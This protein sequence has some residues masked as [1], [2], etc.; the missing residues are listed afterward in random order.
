[1]QRK[2]LTGFSFFF[3]TL[4]ATGSIQPLA[5]H[6]ATYETEQS[7]G[8]Y[9]SYQT[10]D[11]NEDGT[12]DAVALT[13]CD[14]SVTTITVPD[15]I[16]GLP[17]TSIGRSAFAWCSDLVS[18]TLPDTLTT[19]STN[20][21][22]QCESLVSLAIP[23]QVSEIA[24]AA[25]VG[26]DS[27]RF[28][29]VDADNQCYSSQ[30]GVLFDKEQTTLL[31]Y[32]ASHST[33]RYSIP[34]TVTMIYDYAFYECRNL[35]SVTMPDSVTR[36]CSWAFAYC[37]A[38]TDITI[39]DSVTSIST[40]AFYHCSGLKSVSIGSGIKTIARYTFYS[41]SGLQ[42]VS[43]PKTV[44]SIQASAFESCSLLATIN[45]WNPD[46]TI[47]DS[48]ATICNSATSDG[49]FVFYGAV[50]GFADSGA[51]TYANTYGYRFLEFEAYALGDVNNDKLID[52]ADATAVLTAYTLSLLGQSVDWNL[53][54]QTAADI[55]KD[56]L[57]TADDATGILSY[58][59]YTLTGGSDSL[60]T[61]LQ[62]S[63][64]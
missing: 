33:T 47:A 20:A 32:P 6:A 27:L 52:A 56:T 41:C 22:Y 59:V 36:I 58:Y 3:S 8:S 60:E 31:C 53:L 10:I 50:R 23:E 39:P 44:T 5:T 28:I 51:Q 48:A 26:C 57:L 30:N 49:E 38:L 42:T 46:C 4:L 29:S 14:T 19:I 12:A 9:L 61:Y 54:E 15:T 2:K 40:H 16:A 37:N 35:L 18:I 17:V 45:I 34:D 21:F 11:T 13:D 64:A 25:F 43:I 55:N 7:Y 24:V 1:M 63:K 62:N